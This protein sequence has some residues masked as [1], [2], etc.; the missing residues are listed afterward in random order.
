MWD[1]LCACAIRDPEAV[2]SLLLLGELALPF[3]TPP[4]CML[5]AGAHPDTCRWLPG[6]RLNSAWCVQQLAS[7]SYILSTPPLAAGS[8][9]QVRPSWA[10]S[11]WCRR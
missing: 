4:T 10:A 9:P 7:Q 6:A 1:E 8:L 3:Y 5:E 2:W 11:P